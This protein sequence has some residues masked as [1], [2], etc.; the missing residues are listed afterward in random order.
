M[1]TEYELECPCKYDKKK[2]FKGIAY[3]PWC[4]CDAVSLD[5][6]INGLNEDNIPYT[7]M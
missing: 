3:C 2:V 6:L 7:R 1:V 4:F 5:V